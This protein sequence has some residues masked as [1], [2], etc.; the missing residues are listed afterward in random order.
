[1]EQDVVVTSTIL[2]DPGTVAIITDGASTV[3]IN[4]DSISTP[5][6]FAYIIEGSINGSDWFPVVAFDPTT[7]GSFTHGSQTTVTGQWVI[8]CAG[9]HEVRFNLT[10]IAAGS[11]IISMHASAGTAPVLIAGG[12]VALVPSF[13]RLQSTTSGGSNVTSVAVPNNNTATV[14]KAAAGQV[15]AI[16]TYNS[17][18][19]P[20][21]IKMYDALS[22]T[23]GAGTPVDRI[24]I[25]SGKSFMEWPQGV[26]YTTGIT[27]IIVTGIADSDTTAPAAS[28]F[29]V[30][31]YWK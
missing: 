27:A 12:T 22:A 1:M 9:L 6:G 23:A 21:Y 4:L 3:G 19:T 17:G 30:S 24:G 18:G 10:A 13:V 16:A 11:A 5:S 15:Y 20:A 28:T 29:L 2:S 14:V 8:P 25:P 26:P 31:F 7:V